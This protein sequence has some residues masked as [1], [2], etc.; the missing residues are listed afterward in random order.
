MLN[1]DTGAEGFAQAILQAEYIRVDAAA[2]FFLF[3]LLQPARQV[4]RIAHGHAFANH[5]ASRLHL[6]V[7]VERQQGPRMTH[8]DQAHVDHIL[9]LLHQLEQSKQVGNGRAGPSDRVGGFLVGH[10]EVIDQA[11][12]RRGLLQRIEVFALDIFDQRHCNGDF[13][14]H[15]THDRRDGL[16]TGDLRGTPASFAGDQFVTIVPGRA[17]HYRLHHTLRPDRICQLIQL[18]LVENRSRLKAARSDHLERKITQYITGLVLDLLQC[19]L[20]EHR[21]QVAS[22]DGFFSVSHVLGPVYNATLRFS[23]RRSIS[24]A[25]ATW[26]MAPLDCAE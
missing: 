26:A 15:V 12:Q 11:A 3:G 1:P 4:L 16:D 10:L 23:W 20:A 24:P 13:I 5:F 9:D 25:R 8:F 7:V 19:R 17:H 18:V 6:Q 21:A 2:S 22:K 14:R